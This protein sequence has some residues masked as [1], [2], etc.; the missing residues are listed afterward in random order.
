MIKQRKNADSFPSVPAIRQLSVSDINNDLEIFESAVAKQSSDSEHISSRSLRPRRMRHLPQDEDRVT[1]RQRLEDKIR[2]ETETLDGGKT[3]HKVLRGNL[4][5]IR[6]DISVCMDDINRVQRDIDFAVQER[7]LLES[8]FR[9]LQSSSGKQ[10]ATVG[11]V[12]D[13]VRSLSAVERAAKY[14]KEVEKLREEIKRKDQENCVLNTQ[15]SDVQSQLE[16]FKDIFSAAI[17]SP[18]NDTPIILLKNEASSSSQPSRRSPKSPARSSKS[19]ISQSPKSLS[20]RSPKSPIRRSP[21][22][23]IRR[24]PKSPSRRSPRSPTSRSLS[25]PPP[26]SKYE[27]FSK[28]SCEDADMEPCQTVPSISSAAALV[29]QLSTVSSEPSTCSSVVVSDTMPSSV[30]SNPSGESVKSCI[31]DSHPVAIAPSTFSTDVPPDNVKSQPPEPSPSTEPRSQAGV[32]VTS[33]PR[34]NSIVSSPTQQSIPPSG[35]PP[36][37]KTPVSDE[38]SLDSP[39]VPK[40]PLSKPPSEDL[41]P[42]KETQSDSHPTTNS[43]TLDASPDNIKQEIYVSDR[44][45]P[46][47]Q[48]DLPKPPPS[49]SLFEGTTLKPSIDVKPVSISKGRSTLLDLDKSPNVSLNTNVVSDKSETPTDRSQPLATSDKS[50]IADGNTE[51]SLPSKDGVSKSSP[52]SS[53]QESTGS[54][55]PKSKQAPCPEYFSRPQIE[56]IVKKHT[57]RLFAVQQQFLERLK[58]SDKT[59]KSDSVRP[60][61]DADKECRCELDSLESDC[62]LKIRQ[63]SF[64]LKN[65]EKSIQLL[66]SENE[67]LG[68][69]REDEEAASLRNDVEQRRRE[70]IGLADKRVSH[71]ENLLQQSMKQLNVH[72]TGSNELQEKYIRILK[73]C[74]EVNSKKYVDHGKFDQLQNGNVHLQNRVDRLSEQLQSSTRHNVDLSA[75][76]NSIRHEV[77]AARLSLRKS[78]N[79]VFA[80]RAE[81]AELSTRLQ[82]QQEACVEQMEVVTKLLKQVQSLKA[83]RHRSR[84]KRKSFPS[85]EPLAGGGLEQPSSGN[86]K[87]QDLGAQIITTPSGLK[88]IA[89]LSPLT[90]I[91]PVSMGAIHN[92]PLLLAQAPLASRATSLPV[93]VSTNS[94][95]LPARHVVA[96]QSVQPIAPTIVGTSTKPDGPSTQ[97]PESDSSRQPAEPVTPKSVSSPSSSLVSRSSSVNPSAASQSVNSR[98]SK[99]AMH[100][101]SSSS[102]SASL[103]PRT[104]SS[105]QVSL[106]PKTSS[107]AT[108][109]SRPISSLS[110]S[111][112]VSPEKKGSSSDSSTE[113]MEPSSTPSKHKSTSIATSV[114]DSARSRSN[115]Q[116]S[117]GSSSASSSSPPLLAALKHVRIRP[118]DMVPDHQPP[119][120]KF[121]SASPPDNIAVPSASHDLIQSSSDPLSFCRNLTDFGESK[122]SEARQNHGSDGLVN[123]H[124]SSSSRMSPDRTPAMGSGS[125]S[126]PDSN[127][128]QD[129][130]TIHYNKADGCRSNGVP[131]HEWIGA[132]ISC[133]PE[134]KP[135]YAGINIRRLGSP[136][137]IGDYVWLSREVKGKS[138]R[139]LAIVQSIWE[140]PRTDRQFIEGRHFAFVDDLPSETRPTDAL[141]KME[142]FELEKKEQHDVSEI[143]RLVSIYYP[144][145]TQPDP[146]INAYMLEQRRT[147]GDEFF[148]R[149]LFQEETG[150]FISCL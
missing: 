71:A 28:S 146:E 50:E 131:N 114:T 36:S 33:E 150:K 130:V 140:D 99:S 69:L 65:C 133:D 106:Q 3:K 25:S 68:A 18:S 70:E 24:S 91:S 31:S 5:N 92:S 107:P 102:P 64:Q 122:S 54:K 77:E 80:V 62:R 125:R 55:S 137:Y 148:C 59:K 29:T 39:S 126:V 19:P 57:K 12:R 108:S 46:E 78:A 74:E 81:C 93:S 109:G 14:E 90:A 72:E 22:S 83:N 23:P 120:K 139:I 149:N 95:K 147:K 60:T 11:T 51:T 49:D 67:V 134:G 6:T 4:D 123:G 124:R 110:S 115:G 7:N 141:C 121:R 42:S 26:L 21:K 128:L 32:S 89:L 17:P 20:R 13:G 35:Q 75:A 142:V 85:V 143:E 30:S 38:G 105:P 66:K 112:N 100:L 16:F 136:L 94:P 104:P 113:T 9:A 63:L 27:K 56:E 58:G 61:S 82:L 76:N 97:K 86:I 84:A 52:R 8:R 41:P 37:D 47:P 48:S 129:S 88:D 119:Q 1:K 138:T 79:T 98:S 15:V 135:Y 127:G 73:T 111:R 103:P 116:S 101:V 144:P 40:S 43:M 87:L 10:A 132:Q 145:K 45:T 44:I 53:S 2:F 117:P 34:S 118:S 96:G